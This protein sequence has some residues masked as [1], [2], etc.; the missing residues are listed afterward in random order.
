MDSCADFAALALRFEA[1]GKKDRE[2]VLAEFSA[3]DRRL[4]EQA[5]TDQL[6]ASLEE[7][8]RRRRTDRQFQAYSPWLA[9][10]IAEAVTNRSDSTRLTQRAA[11]ALA[12]Q[13]RAIIDLQPDDHNKG[14]VGGARK[15]W[16]SLIGDQP[17]LQP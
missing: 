10:L 2:A 11:L 15:I 1:L 13:H 6:Q 16:R 12:G 7:A 8:D 4:I 14:L 17:E 3:E 5:L 9:D